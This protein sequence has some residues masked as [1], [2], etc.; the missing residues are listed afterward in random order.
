MSKIQGYADTSTHKRSAELPSEEDETREYLL[1]RIDALERELKKYS[2]SS[3]TKIAVFNTQG[4]L[5]VELNKASVIN[6][7]KENNIL[8]IQIFEES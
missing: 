7:M 2:N 6:R 4:D 1:A 5:I 8:D 3:K